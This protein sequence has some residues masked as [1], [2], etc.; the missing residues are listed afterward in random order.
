MVLIKIYILA[1]RYAAACFCEMRKYKNAVIL[2][3]AVI[4]FYLFLHFTLY[5]PFFYY[6][7]F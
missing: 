1:T 3:P 7:A 5:D 4:L 2:I 6:S